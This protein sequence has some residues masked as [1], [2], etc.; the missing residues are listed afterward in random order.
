[1]LLKDT[2]SWLITK[3][4]IARGLFNDWSVKKELGTTWFV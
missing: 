1:M 2:K 4:N 3:G